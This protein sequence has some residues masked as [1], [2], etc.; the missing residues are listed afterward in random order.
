MTVAALTS[1]LEY[2]GNGVTVNFPAPFR[3]LA[4][5]HLA[6]TRVNADATIT[7]LAYGPDFTATAGPTDAGGVVTCAVAPAAGTV[8]RIKRTTPRSQGTDYTTGDTFPAESHEA[9]LDRAMLVD[10]EQDDAIE[11]TASR[12]LLVPDGET[13]ATIPAATDRAGYFLAFGALGIPIRASGTGNDAALRADLASS[14]GSGLVGR[15]R[16]AIGAVVRSLA[17]F[18]EVPVYVKDFGCVEDGVTDDAVNFQ[19]AIDHCLLSTQARTLKV[20]GPIKLASSINIDRMVDTTT[21][22]FRIVGMGPEAGFKVNGTTAFTSTI[23]VSGGQPRSEFIAFEN[24]RFDG[25]GNANSYAFSERMFRMRLINCDFQAIRCLNA[26]TFAQE[27]SFERCRVRSAPDIFFDSQGAYYVNSHGSK[28]QNNAGVWIFDLHHDTYA[29]GVVGC[30]FVQDTAE[31][32]NGGYLRAG[33]I[34]GLTVSGCYFEKNDQATGTTE[35][36][37]DLTVTSGGTNRGV[38]ITGNFFDPT[39]ANIAAATFYDIVWSTGG[40]YSAGNHGQGN[41]HNNAGC[42]Q[43]DLTSIEDRVA[44]GKKLFGTARHQLDLVPD[45]TSAY[46][47]PITSDFVVAYPING[48]AGHTI[49]LPPARR[50]G[51]P[52]RVLNRLGGSTQTFTMLPSTS[53]DG[54]LFRGGAANV[55]V[56]Q[57]PATSRTY[58]PYADGTWDFA[59]DYAQMTLAA[60]TYVAPAGGATIDAQARA[61]LVQLAADV[62]DLRTALQTSGRAA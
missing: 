10:Q 12:A 51:K 55:G 11:D 56:V 30:S 14:G 57:P 53:A 48:V 28:Y 46:L 8:L 7:T 31:A 15:I 26:T 49:A 35:S 1:S 9:A 44:A 23:A 41:L 21:S 47:S 18:F 32:N 50:G 2:N 38:A 60:A 39:A 24:I 25:A 40:G 13:V 52:I 59:T 22:E 37:L 27:W 42:S 20:T 33:A 3:Y 16:T 4:P 19:K 58:Y 5:T 43:I 62:A 6:V 45:A 17:S 34:F 36:T 61:S 54:G 29:A